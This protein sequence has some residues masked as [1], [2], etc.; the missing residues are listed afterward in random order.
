MGGA[1]L[2]GAHRKPAYEL[3]HGRPV[4]EHLADHPDE[5]EQFNAAMAAS[6]EVDG[7]ALVKACGLSRVSACSNSVHHEPT[8][9]PCLTN[10]I[11]SRCGTS[12]L[13]P[14]R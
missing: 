13:D 6:A 8:A 4:W 9:L 1:G 7:K 3:V 10:V 14:A 11:R 2:L 5:T 12:D